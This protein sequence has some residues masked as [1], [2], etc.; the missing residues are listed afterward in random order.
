MPPGELTTLAKAGAYST[1][2]NPPTHALCLQCDRCDLSL[3][4]PKMGTTHRNRKNGLGKDLTTEKQSGRPSNAFSLPSRFP[5]L[6]P[7]D[8]GGRPDI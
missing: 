4:P 1:G 8:T 6:L 3:K 7:L 5:L 2:G